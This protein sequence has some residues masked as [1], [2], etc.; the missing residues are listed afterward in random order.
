MLLNLK[1]KKYVFV[2]NRPAVL[3]NM[4][5]KNLK[6]TKVC[7]IKDSFLTRSPINKSL[8]FSIIESKK[9]LI[10]ELN[11]IYFDIL[12]LNGCPYIIPI[13][14]Y[15]NKNALLLNIHPSYLPNLRGADP[16]PGALLKSE[17]SGA[18]C[19]IIDGGIDTGDI[20]SQI[21]IPYTNDLDID[22]LYRLS[23]IC[24][25]KV[26]DMAFTRGF[27][28]LKK[29]Q[30]S[31]LNSYYTRSKDDQIIN[32]DLDT[33]DSIVSKILAFGNKSQGVTFFFQELEFKV[34]FAKKLH[35]PFLC[36]YS[37]KFLNGDVIFC[38][39]DVIIFKFC[40]EIIYFNKVKG[41]IE[42]ISQSSNFLCNK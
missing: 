37:K 16:V 25:S 42:K 10:D 9:N 39:E 14:G 15:K 19:H 35:N 27:K 7:A 13:S 32:F 23:F 26:F 2:G 41:P 11:S 8:N 38:Y 28:I 20:I 36:E 31:Q 21:E 34:F 3:E 30:K 18:T 1:D 12:I 17:N 24:E 5:S 29:Q 40:N 33:P 4:I 22:L 6:I